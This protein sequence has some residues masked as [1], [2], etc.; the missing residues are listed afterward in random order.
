VGSSTRSIPGS[1]AS[2]SRAEWAKE[3]FRRFGNP[4]VGDFRNIGLLFGE[5]CVEVTGE[6]EVKKRA[7]GMGMIY[8]RGSVYWIKY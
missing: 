3:I 6:G 5:R 7:D 8:K 4:A 2:L 1:S